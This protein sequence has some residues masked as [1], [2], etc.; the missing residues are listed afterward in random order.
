VLI[1]IIAP[2]R[3]PQ[4]VAKYIEQLYVDR[5]ASIRERLNYKKSPKNFPY[6]THIGLYSGVMHCGQDPVLHALQSDRI[7]LAG[8]ELTFTYKILVR[9]DPGHIP[10]FE[11]GPKASRLKSKGSN[12]SEVFFCNRAHG[13][14]VE[15]SGFLGA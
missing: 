2:R 4:F 6:R 14:L 11:V 1:S 7:M 12:G 3:S 8:N 5:Y 15:P 13:N 10:V 9:E